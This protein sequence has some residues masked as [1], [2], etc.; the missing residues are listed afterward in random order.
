MLKEH[1][2]PPRV[3]AGAFAELELAIRWKRTNEA[4]P[5]PQERFGSHA[6]YI[7]RI[8]TRARWGLQKLE[9]YSCRLTRRQYYRC[10]WQQTNNL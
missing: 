10:W 7:E 4:P 2:N 1:I 5:C 6:S 8:I 3:A 9:A